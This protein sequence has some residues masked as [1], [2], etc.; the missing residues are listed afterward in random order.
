MEQMTITAKIQII[1]AETD[2]Y[3]QFTSKYRCFAIN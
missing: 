2:N 3:P 1:V